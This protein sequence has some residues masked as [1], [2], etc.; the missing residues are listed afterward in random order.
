M[1]FKPDAHDFEKLDV[2]IAV[3]QKFNGVL[4]H[5]WHQWSGTHL[6]VW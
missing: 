6:C 2:E 5:R 3:D 1:A 4:D